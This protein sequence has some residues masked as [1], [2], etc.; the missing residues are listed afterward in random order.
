[1]SNWCDLA[2]PEG[3]K[4]HIKVHVNKGANCTL[5]CA[6]TSKHPCTINYAHFLKKKTEKIF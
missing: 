2:L 5:K 1:M 6:L 4:L 3:L